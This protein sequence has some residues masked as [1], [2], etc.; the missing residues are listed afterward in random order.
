MTDPDTDTLSFEDHLTAVQD[1]IRKLERGEAPL[2][3]SIDLYAEAMRHL[4]RCNSVL[5]DAEKRLEIVRRQADGSSAAEPAAI[6]D[7]GG[8]QPLGG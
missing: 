2:E 4:Q 6:D 1:A 8:V 7:A 3:D 5:A